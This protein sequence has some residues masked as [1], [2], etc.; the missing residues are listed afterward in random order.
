MSTIWWETNKDKFCL[1]FWWPIRLEIAVASYVA[2]WLRA[3]PESGQ[4]KTIT[5]LMMRSSAKIMNWM[6][7][8]S[9]FVH[10]AIYTGPPFWNFIF[11]LE[12]RRR[13][14][15]IDLTQLPVASQFSFFIH[16]YSKAKVSTKIWYGT[17]LF[18]LFW[19]A[20]HFIGKAAAAETVDSSAAAAKLLP[21]L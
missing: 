2:L 18:S 10:V 12:L 16:S 15:I 20:R 7:T 5:K 4:G 17:F 6:E 21:C 13:T 8:I 11:N 14:E 1:P 3:I 9:V 19:I